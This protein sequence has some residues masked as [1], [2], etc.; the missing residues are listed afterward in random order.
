MRIT[1]IGHATT[2]L[3]LDG[4]RILTDPLLRSRVVHLHR[5]VPIGRA[6]TDA[7]GRPDGILITHLHFDHFDPPSIKRFDRD[8]PVVVPRGGAVN[9]L[10]R[11]GFRHVR[12][13]G[14]GTVFKLGTVEVRAVHAEH[15]GSRGTPWISGPA[16]GYVLRGSESIYFAGDTDSF[17]EMAAFSG[18]DVALLPVAGWGPR[19][20]EGEHMNPERAAIA[21]RTL[22]PRV[23]IP[24]HW[25]TYTPIWARGGYAANG[26]AAEDFRRFAAKEAPEV[27]VRVLLPG[28]AVTVPATPTH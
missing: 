8:V 5:L 14:E 18:V 1:Y 6:E 12:G 15:P 22:R 19:L 10:R 26:T 11:R 21:L 9:L 2:L 20:P 25:G 28:E 16:L 27:D 24:I 4:V 3:E 7:L 13:V 23:A 17:P